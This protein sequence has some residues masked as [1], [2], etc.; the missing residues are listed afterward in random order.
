MIDAT[1]LAVAPGFIDLHSHGQ[2]PENYRLKAYDGVTTA[3]ELEVGAAPL[4]AWYAARAGKAAINFG[5]SSGF[6]PSAM[7]VMGDTGGLLPRDK[8]KN[9]PTAEE[10]RR[11]FERVKEGLDAGAL[12]IGFGLEYVPKAPRK[13]I[14]DLFTLAAKR[15]VPCFVHLRHQGLAEPGVIEGLQEVIANAVATA[16][17]CT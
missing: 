17:P 7:A 8:A 3:L 5:A 16:H 2:T 11:I 13:D 9:R 1:G 14:L 4:P 12:G 10:S 6:I 15:G